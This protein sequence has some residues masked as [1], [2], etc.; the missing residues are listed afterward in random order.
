MP[1]EI[2]V[3]KLVAEIILESQTSGADEA[4]SKIQDVNTAAGNGR[5]TL[6]SCSD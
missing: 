4:I 2:N 5:I 1:E 6:M 3:G